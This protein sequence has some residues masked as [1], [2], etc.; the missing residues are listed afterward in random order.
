MAG[1]GEQGSGVGAVLGGVGERAVA[2]LV[3]GERSAGQGRCRVFEQFGGAPVG[4]P[5]LAG[6]GVQVSRRQL[7]AG[8]AGGEEERAGLAGADHAGAVVGRCLFA[9]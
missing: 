4:Q 3:Q 2:Q 6:S 5:G 7:D 1:V 8:G 9:R